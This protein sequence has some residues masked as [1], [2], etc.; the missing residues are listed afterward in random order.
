VIFDSDVLI[1]ALRGNEKAA[2][3]IER[4]PERAVSVI[5]C[6]ELLDGIRDKREMTNLHHFLSNFDRIPLTE[7]IGHRAC[8]YMEQYTLKTGLD[9]M[10]ALIAATAVEYSQTLCTGN[11]KHYRQIA[12]LDMRTFRS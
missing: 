5:S 6:L 2:R 4:E 1:W 7:A 10:D 8:L 3:A 12:E 11:A 9:P